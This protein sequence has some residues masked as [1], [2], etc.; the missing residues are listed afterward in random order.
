MATITLSILQANGTTIEKTMTSVVSG[1]DG[2]VQNTQI[3]LNKRIF[4]EW[5]FGLTYLLVAK[6]AAVDKVKA[7]ALDLYKAWTEAD[8]PSSAYTPYFVQY[9][10]TADPGR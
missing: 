8:N 2:F 5:L 6:N 3:T 7:D 9:Q 10:A 1:A 4:N